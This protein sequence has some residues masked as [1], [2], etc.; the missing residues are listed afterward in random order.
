MLRE[1]RGVWGPLL[2]AVALEQEVLGR[3]KTRA[4]MCHA[5]GTT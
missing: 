5:E 2:A 3:V 4:W 1:F